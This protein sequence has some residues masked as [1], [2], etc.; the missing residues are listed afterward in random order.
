[1]QKHQIIQS[2]NSAQTIPF[3][4]TYHPNMT[5]IFDYLGGGSA[6]FEI[7]RLVANQMAAIMPSLPNWIRLRRAFVS[8]AAPKLTCEGFEQFLDLGT[9]MPSEDL[10]HSFVDDVIIIYSDINIVAISYSQSFFSEMPLVDYIFGDARELDAVF[11]HP[12]VNQL[13]NLDKKVAIGLNLLPLILLPADMKRMAQELYEWAPIGSQLFLI[14]QCRGENDL[15]ESYSEFIQVTESTGMPLRLHSLKQNLEMLAPWKPLVFEPITSF[16][17]LP[18]DF[19]I[20]TEE[21][22]ISM[23]FHA[24]FFVK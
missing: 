11:N 2:P 3:L 15:P 20:G 10:I 12:T 22:G 17:G 6:N 18:N 8:E 14:L 7:D 23:T 4:D 1:M 19:D 21:D 24:V 9:G 13:L 5:R 16:L